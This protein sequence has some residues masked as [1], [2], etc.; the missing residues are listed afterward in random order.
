MSRWSAFVILACGLLL[1]SPA[2]AIP[3]VGAAR[4]EIRLIDAW[5]RTFS[6]GKTGTKP[7]L[8]IYEDKDSATQNRT[9]KD[10]LAKLAKGDRYK[11]AV[12]LIAIADVAGYDYWPIRGFVKDAIQEESVKWQTPIYCD[13]NGAFRSSLGLK[14]ST[15]TVILYGKDGR[16][17]L[18]HEG[19]MPASIRRNLVA[20]LRAE[21]GAPS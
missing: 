16:V 12:A 15:S 21:V 9:L 17:L 5:D 4:P 3:E 14:K 2:H 20:L 6:I 19:S 8:I 7:I 11:N 18:S 13:W 1:S 10:D